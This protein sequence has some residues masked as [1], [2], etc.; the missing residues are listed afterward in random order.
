MDFLWAG[1]GEEGRRGGSSSEA[2]R[3]RGQM[4]GDG[5]FGVP[6]DARVIRFR[7]DGMVGGV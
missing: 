1:E 6:V 3:L 2:L 4:A 7:G 5:D